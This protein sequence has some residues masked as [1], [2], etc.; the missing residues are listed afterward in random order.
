MSSSHCVSGNGV[1]AQA[2]FDPNTA[3]PPT[4]LYDI[5]G[6]LVGNDDINSQVGLSRL[7][8]IHFLLAE[9]YSCKENR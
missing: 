4:P 8:Q 5:T 1:R 7:S 6:Q 3:C 2:P 9:V